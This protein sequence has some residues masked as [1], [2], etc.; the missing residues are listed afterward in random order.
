MKFS[1]VV[2]T[3][4]VPKRKLGPSYYA[5]GASWIYALA[6][7]LLESATFDWTCTNTLYL[8]SYCSTFSNQSESSKLGEPLPP[9]ITFRPNFKL[10]FREPHLSSRGNEG[11][12]AEWLDR[13]GNEM[14]V[15][16]E[17]SPK[18]SWR[19][20][21]GMSEK[22]VHTYSIHAR[23]EYDMSSHPT[24]TLMRISYG[25]SKQMGWEAPAAI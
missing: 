5:L 17:C 6:V 13:L 9:T 8:Q 14:R 12:R 3:S 11:W 22:R 2:W 4:G 10:C 21:L 7:V 18:A 25:P 23:F 19:T 15:L 16:C 24:S 20:Q 1:L